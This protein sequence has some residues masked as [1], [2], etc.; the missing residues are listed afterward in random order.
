MKTIK[1]FK[2]MSLVI[3]ITAVVSCEK[4]DTSEIT[5]V[6][7]IKEVAKIDATI[8]KDN[9]IA[10][11]DFPEELK[12]AVPLSKQGIDDSAVENKS[13]AYS[14]SSY[15]GTG[16]NYFSVNPPSGTK[17]YAIAIRSGRLVDR[18]T[19]YYRGTNG[20]IYTGFSEGGSGGTYALHFFEEDEYIERMNVR[21][22]RLIDRLY[23]E[24]NYKSFGYGGNGG[25]SYSI[26][27][28]SSTHHI[29]GFYGRSARLVDQ[30]GFYVHT[31]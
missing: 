6:E 23:F 28:P 13:F 30:I 7:T 26:D 19:V 11:E 22:G 9:W 2:V 4:G 10:W 14:T 15:G 27:I 5:E 17:I 24:T 20:A 18:I 12:N 25:T 21:A 31:K 8:S 3:V 1:L 29:L 16:G